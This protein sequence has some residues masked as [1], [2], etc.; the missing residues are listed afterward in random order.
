M[1]VEVIANEYVPSA[2]NEEA[3]N[4]TSTHVLTT[5][6]PIVPAWVPRAG[7]LFQLIVV[8]DH[9]AAT[10]N[11]EPPTGLASVV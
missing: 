11:T 3:G 9:A 6:A 2:V 7:L 8:S 5:T 10:G 1:F 4:V